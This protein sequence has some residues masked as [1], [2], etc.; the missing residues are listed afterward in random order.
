MITARYVISAA[1]IIFLLFVFPARSEALF[2]FGSRYQKVEAEEGMVKIP[3]SDVDDGEAHY[4]SYAKDGR[5]IRFFVLQSPDGVIRSAFDACDV[6][7]SERKGYDRV[8]SSVVCNNCGQRFHSSM[9]NEVKG[10]CNPA[11]LARE[12]RDGSLVIRVSDIEKGARYF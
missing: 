8:G 12:R 5:E 3:V 10:G 4:Y 2:G 6:C 9:I 11:P 7:Y 1:A